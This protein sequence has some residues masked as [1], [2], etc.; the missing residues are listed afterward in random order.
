M[1]NDVDGSTAA[2]GAV[3]AGDNDADAGALPVSVPSLTADGK[4]RSCPDIS[5]E[6]GS[7]SVV[8]SSTSSSKELL[9][10]GN[11]R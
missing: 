1:L 4:L 7:E 10:D 9:G 2:D 8:T 6:A 3:N 5:G 11:C